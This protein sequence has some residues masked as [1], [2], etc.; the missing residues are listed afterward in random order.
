MTDT[1]PRHA[2][3]ES[4]T[5]LPEPSGRPG[6][7]T[8]TIIAVL[9]VA[10]GL[11]L[12]LFFVVLVLPALT[13][14]SNDGVQTSD[15]SGQGG[16]EP[17][18]ATDGAQ[19]ER[20]DDGLVVRIDVPTP[21]PGSYEYPTGDMVSPWAEP[22]PPVSPGAANAPEVFTVWMIVFNDPTS[23][24]D[25]QCDV[26]DTAADARARGGVYQLDGRV[27]DEK[28]M[29]FF[30]NIRVGQQTETGSPLDN[31]N[32]ADVHLAIAPHGR[33][34]SG[35]DGWRQLN[36]PVGNPTLWWDAAFLPNE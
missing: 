12:L 23:C 7:Q 35:T 11:L 15:V 31:P 13:S 9:A 27:A 33:A 32:G 17:A 2:R 18:L 24:T 3:A 16:A 36:G 19:L 14:E 21:E 20:R 6:R 5:S 8:A 22:H 29:S 26:D 4:T 10:V 1:Q 25:D 28:S 30:G 34:L